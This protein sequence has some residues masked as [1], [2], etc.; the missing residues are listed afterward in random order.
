MPSINGRCANVPHE[1]GERVINTDCRATE[2]RPKR[3]GKLQMV[4]IH[5]IDGN[6]ILEEIPLASARD[7]LVD[8]V[9][10]RATR[11]LN[12]C[13]LIGGWIAWI[14]ASA[15]RVI[16]NALSVSRLHKVVVDV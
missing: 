7:A 6:G 5:V 4:K 12:I 2:H 10:N 14:I 3:Q 15:G 8:P 16:A 1:R 13:A 11:P 9:F